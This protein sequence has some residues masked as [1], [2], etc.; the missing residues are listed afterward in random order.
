MKK[1][2]FILTLLLAVTMTAKAGDGER[3]IG[4]QGG[5]LYP[6]MLNAVLS[7]DFET[8]YHNAFE[9][10]V[11]AFTEWD[12]CRDCS[13][14]CKQSFWQSN[15]G[16]AIGAAYK[17][18]AI[19]SRNSVGRF[20]LGGDLGTTSREFSLGIEVGYEH[21]WHFKNNVQIVLQQKNELTFWGRPTWRL[22]GLVGI[23]FP[24]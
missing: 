23:R 20:R 19:R 16:L 15:Y 7:V 2:L 9:V 8:R 11:D 3:H 21:V 22:G 18:T 6:G 1:H 12:E 5:V 24:L 13:K 10:Y 17:P 4:I 14:V